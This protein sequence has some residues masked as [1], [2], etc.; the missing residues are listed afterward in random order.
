M[1]S[2]GGDPGYGEPG[3]LDETSPESSPEHPHGLGWGWIFPALWLGGRL[4][5][6]MGSPRPG[7]GWRFTPVPPAQKPDPNRLLRCQHCQRLIVPEFTS[8]PQCG[9]HLALAACHYC[10]QSLPRY[11]AECDSCGAPVA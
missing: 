6:L 4:S 7:A 8:C 10:G 5:S 3:D 11:T 2:D 1:E 9:D